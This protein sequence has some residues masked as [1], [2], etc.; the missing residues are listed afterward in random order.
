MRLIYI[1]T[2]DGSAPY[3]S[4]PAFDM[5]PSRNSY[6]ADGMYTEGFY[7]LWKRCLEEKILDE[8]VTVIESTR[9]PGF[10]DY[11]PHYRAL[12][13]PEIGQLRPFLRP[14]DLIFA[15]GGFRNWFTFLQELRDC[16]H[17]LMFYA[18]AQYHRYRWPFWHIL[19]NDLIDASFVE[20]SGRIQFAFKKPTSPELF[21]PEQSGTRFSLC[22]GASHIHDKKAQ[23]KVV[24]AALEYQRIFGQKLP[25]ILPG[26]SIKGVETNAIWGKLAQLDIQVPGMVPRQVMRSIYSRSSLFVHL[27]G[28]GQNDRG[29]LE[30]MQ[31]GTPVMMAN[32]RFHA[33]F[34]YKD[35]RIT[36]ITKNADDPAALAMEIRELLPRLPKREEV[37]NYYRQ[38][39]DFESVILP[40]VAAFFDVF[41]RRG[42][43]DEILKIT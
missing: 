38:E 26:R 23:Y 7:Y 37:L 28:S 42:S 33:P 14:D 12:V 25:C 29:V 39:S 34:T 3:G 21:Y 1:F 22:I 18:A 41:R 16:G 6:A 19:W 43:C 30:A 31:C 13:L 11:A 32:P 2:A 17:I 15:R 40:R 9:S 35:P 36:R 4:N 24:N 10:V 27:G 5:A 20:P 8:V